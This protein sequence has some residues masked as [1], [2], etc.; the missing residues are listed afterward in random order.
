M[1]VALAVCVAAVAIIGGNTPAW[2]ILGGVDASPLEFPYMVSIQRSGQ[3]S[4]A[5][6][7]VTPDEVWTAARCVD[8]ALATTLSVVAGLLCRSDLSGT[9]ARAVESYDIWPTYLEPPG[10]YSNDLAIIHLDGA[11]DIT[12]ANVDLAVLPPDNTEQF[13]G[14]TCTLVG[15]G[16]TGPDPCGVTLPDCLQ[17]ADVPVIST[18]EADLRLNPVGADVTAC[19]IA[20]HDPFLTKGTCSGDLGGP[21]VCPLNGVSV[22]AGII[23]WSIT[24]SGVCLPVFPSVQT[25]TSCY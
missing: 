22:V 2:A 10:T 6:V 20:V 25:R 15:W 19:H 13:V 16:R 23:S 12:P 7:L 4:C 11:F 8:G 14:V 21:L 9:Q 5:G 18:A 24:S 17:K 3:H 1:G